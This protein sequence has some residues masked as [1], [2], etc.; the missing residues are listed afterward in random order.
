[1]V[2]RQDPLTPHPDRF[3]PDHPRYDE[4]LSMHRRAVAAGQDMYRDPDSGLYV[5]TAQYHLNRGRCCQSGCRHCPYV[6]QDA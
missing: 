5:L 3:P 1:M 2:P 4:V 6:G